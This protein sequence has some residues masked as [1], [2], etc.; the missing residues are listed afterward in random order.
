MNVVPGGK[1]TPRPTKPM[2]T[3][4]QTQVEQLQA[5]LTAATDREKRALADYQN[6]VRRTQ[7]DRARSA[8][9]ASLEFVHSLLQPLDHLS[10][11]AAQLQD[12]GLNMV[13]QQ[14][15]KALQ[16]QGLEEITVL[17]QPFDPEL[18][19]VVDKQGEGDTVQKVV[20]KGYRLNGEVI[21][22][23]QVIIG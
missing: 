16:E 9:L 22:V 5:Q 10:L 11:A 3:D 4:T 8:K 17:H 21:Q 12:Q 23:A 13:V 19:E 20:K 6:L 2:T 7:E 18:M 15:W 1:K 14:L